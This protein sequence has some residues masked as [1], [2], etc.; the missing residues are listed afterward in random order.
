MSRERKKDVQT[1]TPH[2]AIIWKNTAFSTSRSQKYESSCPTLFPSF[3]LQSNGKNNRLIGITNINQEVPEIKS[4][5]RNQI[6]LKNLSEN[7]MYNTH[8]SSKLEPISN[9]VGP[10]RLAFQILWEKFQI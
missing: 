8:T 2:L 5:K 10:C 3:F 6:G 7:T 9:F 4:T 1:E